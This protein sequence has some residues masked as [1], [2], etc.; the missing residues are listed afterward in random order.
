MGSTVNSDP[1][2]PIQATR[3][4][5]VEARKNARLTVKLLLTPGQLRRVLLAEG[6][7][8]LGDA[9]A[10]V[11]L[12][13][14]AYQRLRSPWALSAVLLADCLPQIVIAPLAGVLADRVSRRA[15]LIGADV[16]RAGALVGLALIPSFAATVALA[17]VLGAGAALYRPAAQAS[18][19]VLT[20]DPEQAAC[21]VSSRLTIITLGQLLGWGLAGVMFL[22]VS[23]AAVLLFDAA[24]FV[25][26][27][28]VIASTALDRASDA[29][30]EESE[31]GGDLQML[32]DGARATREIAGISPLL[33]TA[34]SAVLA[35]GIINV[36]EPL[37]A[38]NV[39]GAGNA[40]F[41]TLVAAFGVGLV[42]GTGFSG[43]RG[44]SISSLRRTY[45]RAQAIGA[46]G[47]AIMAVAPA[48]PIAVLG[49]VIA[50]AGNGLELA[51]VSQLIQLTVPE[52]LIGRISSLFNASEAAAIMAAFLLGGAAVTLLGVRE[53]FAI[54][55]VGLLVTS[56]GGFLRMRRINESPPPPATIPAPQSPTL[57]VS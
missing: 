50:G 40:G 49:S 34:L 19:P 20:N 14:I 42:L 21:A 53:T 16:V 41:T 3:R 18:V 25:V 13:L 31:R 5:L 48:L 45:V 17:G 4:A 27:V 37:L 32:R 43:P 15:C 54:A 47:I 55:A 26:S 2:T 46:F 7:S 8:A 56:V 35:G 52:K 24:T 12:L 38:K 9:A 23:P 22:A 36:G 51:R 57:L 6:Q 11:A 10:Y 44:R 30:R 1:G 33:M 28:S 39:L 29:E